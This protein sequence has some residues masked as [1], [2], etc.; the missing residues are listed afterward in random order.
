MIQTL[1]CHHDEMRQMMEQIA[2][3]VEWDTAD[4]ALLSRLRLRFSRL[5]HAHLA[6]ERAFFANCIDRAVIETY[7]L[8]IRT[9]LPDYSAH[10]NTWTPSAISAD[11]NQYFEHTRTLQARFYAMMEWEE[12]TLFAS[13]IRSAAA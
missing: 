12:A 9:L 10:V 5:F 7:D 4:L 6:A 11:Q 3:V 2:Q 1:K 8:N 13:P